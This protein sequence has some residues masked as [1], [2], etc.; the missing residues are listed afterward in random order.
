M[1]KQKGSKY[2][3]KKPEAYGRKWDS[4]MELEFYEKLLEEQKQGQVVNI[5]LQPV[6]LLQ[7]KYI[8]KGKTIRKMEYKADFKVTYTDG[9]VI[10]YDVKGMIAQPFPIKWKLVRYIYNDLDFRCVRSKGR[11]PNK[12]WEEIEK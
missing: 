10:I 1:F 5:E 8:Y 9:S 12:I 2:N 6:F 3:N 7:D 4:Q 11:K